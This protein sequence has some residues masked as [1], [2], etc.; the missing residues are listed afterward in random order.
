MTSLAS[1]PGSHMNVLTTRQKGVKGEK[2][3]A[4]KPPRFGARLTP[5]KLVVAL[6]TLSLLLVL[7]AGFAM[8][9]GS[10]S[11]SVGTIVN[12]I[13]GRL[14]GQ[15][16]D[17]TPEQL[18]II[19]DIRLPRVLLAVIV[20]ASLSVAGS[21]YQALLRNPLADPYILGVSTGAAVGAI[22]STVFA[23]QMPVG[24]PIAAFVGATLTI[25]AVYFLG[26][27]HRG[28]SNE[29]LILAGVII[30]SF[31]SS[32]VIFLMTVSSGA[33][34]R[35]VFA[36]LIGDLS[37]DVKRISFIG[38]F[39]VCGIAIIFL[40]SRSLN[41]LMTGE[42]D[43]QA[44]GVDVRR[45]KILVYLASSLI[46]GAA[47]AVSGVIGFVGL[48]V[49]HAVRLVSGS[50]NRLVVP[51]SALVG[52]IFLVLCDTVAR[53]VVAPQELHIGVITALIGAPVFVYLLRRAT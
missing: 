29:R 48:I 36:W 6:L 40:Q 53:T 44:L 21:A 41:L 11:I 31:L 50:D 24:R 38:A 35:S 27:A 12:I 22:A 7:V 30:N 2:V 42:E 28:A 13:V 26:Q 19:S 37:G 4:E 39:A 52:A 32:A 3:E 46:T 47:V 49:P 16:V 18:I 25:S 14:T 33:R 15:T 45:V 51:A 8:L 5:R 43:A 17:A 10:E 20:G 1:Q 34:L 23:E 9:V